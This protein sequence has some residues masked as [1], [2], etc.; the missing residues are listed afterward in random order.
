M[1]PT[2]VRFGDTYINTQHIVAIYPDVVVGRTLIRVTTPAITGQEK[3]CEF[4][5]AAEPGAVVA[6]VG[7]AVRVGRR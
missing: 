4:A 5:V 6:H 7:G 2:F 1:N 3:S